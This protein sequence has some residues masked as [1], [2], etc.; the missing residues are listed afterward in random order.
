MTDIQLITLHKELK[1]KAASLGLNLNIDG[2]NFIIDNGEKV[3]IG[4]VGLQM[5]SDYLLGYQ[6]G[7]E[8]SERN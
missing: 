1:E 3:L 6:M 2:V 4:Y 5:C 7:K 8:A